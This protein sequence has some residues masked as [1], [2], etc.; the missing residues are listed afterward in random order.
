M[1][2]VAVAG[3]PTRFGMRMLGRSCDR[4]LLLHAN[5]CGHSIAQVSGFKDAS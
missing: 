5:W 1:F 3:L 4:E 2:A